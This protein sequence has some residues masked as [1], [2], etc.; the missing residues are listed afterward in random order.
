MNIPTPQEQ[1]ASAKALRAKFFPKTLPIVQRMPQPRSVELVRTTYDHCRNVRAVVYPGRVYGPFPLDERFAKCAEVEFDEAMR[2]VREGP[3]PKHI[4]VA[5]ARKYGLPMEAILAP[6]RL[7]RAVDARHE[8]MAAV[9]VQC[10]GL[11]L[12]DIGRLFNRDHTTCLF[13]IKKHGV[14]RGDQS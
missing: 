10:P 5:I 11:S 14:W 4:I 8:A 7:K 9:Y 3:N 13:A 12:P 6:I 1:F 2:A